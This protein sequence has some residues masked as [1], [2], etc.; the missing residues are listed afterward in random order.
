MHMRVG[1][2]TL[3]ISI[4]SYTQGLLRHHLDNKSLLLEASVQLQHQ[5][6]LLLELNRQVVLVRL[7]HNSRPVGYLGL[8]NLEPLTLV[9]HLNHLVVHLIQLGPLQVLAHLLVVFLEQINKSQVSS[10][11]HLEQ[12]V[13]LVLVLDS[14]QRQLEGSDHQGPQDLEQV[15]PHLV[16][17]HHLQEV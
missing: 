14:D 7:L 10:E 12:R 15:P 13:L 11:L 8:R 3:K 6:H 9:Q 1:N 4:F 2:L 17:L 16:A 5:L